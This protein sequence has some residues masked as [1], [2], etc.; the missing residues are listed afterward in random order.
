LK[1]WE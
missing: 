1:D